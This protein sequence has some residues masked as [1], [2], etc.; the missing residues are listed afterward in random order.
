MNEY[1]CEKMNSL[2]AW[3]GIIGMV[4]LVCHLFSW[5]FLLFVLLIV[6]PDAKFSHAFARLSNFI[7]SKVGHDHD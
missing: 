4:L 6:I 3:L 5:L 1:L 2:T 7:K